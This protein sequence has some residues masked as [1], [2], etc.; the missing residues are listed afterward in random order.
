MS[1]TLHDQ[2]IDSKSKP[3]IG[4]NLEYKRF[5]IKNW[6]VCNSSGVTNVVLKFDKDRYMTGEIAVLDI[7]V[8]NVN[9]SKSIKDI[10]GELV[11]C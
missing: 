5:Q 4:E 10:K 2:S 7:E 11:Q 1:N 9:C 3:E 8:D 6:C